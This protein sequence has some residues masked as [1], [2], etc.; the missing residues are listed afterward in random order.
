MTLAVALVPRCR[1]LSQ[2]NGGIDSPLPDVIVLDGCPQP[3]SA[4]FGFPRLPE[5]SRSELFSSGG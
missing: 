5:I 1:A 2:T 3:P 4:P